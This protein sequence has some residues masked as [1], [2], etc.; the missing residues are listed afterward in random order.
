MIGSTGA[1]GG[2]VARC[3]SELDSVKALTLL[4]RR[5]TPNLDGANVVQHIVDVTEPSSYADLIADHDVAVCT[6]GVGDPSKVDK[7]SFVRIDKRAVLDFAA[8]CSEADVR[9]FELLSSVGVGSGS[10]SFYLR[11]KGELEDGLRALEFRRLSLFHPSMILTPTNRYG[12]S[13][14]ITLKAWPWL[15][16]VLRGSMRKLRGIEV[17]T[18]GEAMAQNVLTD[19]SGEETLEWDDFVRLARR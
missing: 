3:L 9:H 2:H 17:H 16:P 14:A 19:G 12:L 1:V 8:A 5:T 15:K 6:L 11:T 7:E 18:L 13:Q 4:G 10:R